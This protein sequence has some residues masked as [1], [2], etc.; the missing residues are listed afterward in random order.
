[1]INGS[2]RFARGL[3]YGTHSAEHL[4]NVPAARMSLDPAQ[5]G[6]FVDWLRQ[7]DSAIDGHEFVSRQRY[8]EYL[9]A[10]LA[11]REAACPG[12]ELRQR[13]ALVDDCLP[14]PQGWQLDFVDGPPA[15]FDAVILAIGT[16]H[17]AIRIAT[18][19]DC[20]VM[21]PTP[22]PATR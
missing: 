13:V 22:G 6:H 18:S 19:P 16:C 21:W 1:M 11:Q 4:L 12:V 17:H 20:P 9:L 3:A 8:G 7:D 2:G 5:P 15:A 14:T 10:A